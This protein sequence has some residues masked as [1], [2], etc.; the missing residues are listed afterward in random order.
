[1]RIT[2]SD[3]FVPPFFGDL[4]KKINDLVSPRNF[5][6]SKVI[7]TKNKSSTG[8]TVESGF[9]GPKGFAK[10]GLKCK[11]YGK[12]DVELNTAGGKAS[13]TKITL[14][15][16]FDGLEVVV[17]NSMAPSGSVA[18]KYSQDFFAVDGEFK[19]EKEKPTLSASGTVGVDGWG[20]GGSVKYD[21]TTDSKVDDF[22]FGTQYS[23]DDLTVSLVT[24][25]KGEK[26]TASFFQKLSGLSL[27]GQLVVKPLSNSKILT[28]GGSYKYDSN[29]KVNGTVNN[30]GIANLS[31]KHSLSNAQ[32]TLAN[33]Y[34]FSADKTTKIGVGIAFGDF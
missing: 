14:N 30:N 3:I 33:Q 12:A 10:I 7:K 26:I 22:A 4:G 29:T 34:D 16:L 28:I 15:Q 27:A 1:L 6:F 18:A 9:K 23:Q 19:Y 21:F 8:L 17:S 32:L 24:A 13:K 5:D 2:M 31:V 11:R 20:V 25:S